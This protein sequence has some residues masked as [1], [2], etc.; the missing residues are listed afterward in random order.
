MFCCTSESGC[1]VA[2]MR[3]QICGMR[4]SINFRSEQPELRNIANHNWKRSATPR[5]SKFFVAC[6]RH[7][8]RRRGADCVEVHMVGV[9]QE[10]EARMSIFVL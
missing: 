3:E 10:R 7:I 8:P 9:C 4:D 5:G 2:K 6:R 1:L